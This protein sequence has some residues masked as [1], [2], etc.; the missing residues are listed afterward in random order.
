MVVR[1]VKAAGKRQP[2]EEQDSNILLPKH[3][4]QISDLTDLDEPEDVRLTV[5]T[6]PTVPTVLTQPPQPPQPR[7]PT[8][9]TQAAPAAGLDARPAACQPRDP[10]HRKYPQALTSPS[11]HVVDARPLP[12]QASPRG[13]VASPYGVQQGQAQVGAM[14]RGPSPPRLVWSHVP[15]AA[16]RIPPRTTSNVITRFP[17]CFSQR[18][19]CNNW[20]FRG[21][22]D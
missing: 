12:F 7:Q 14:M 4:R 13:V 11:L 6:V 18:S 9:P 2:G 15:G 10:G 16:A 22:E 8:Q 3:V 17:C 5:P 19:A 1:K 20:S 21:Q